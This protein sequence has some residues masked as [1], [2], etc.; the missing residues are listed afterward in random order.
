MRGGAQFR[1]WT[2]THDLLAGVYDAINANTV[3]TG[4]FKK[5]PKIPPWPR[6]TRKPKRPKTV[7]DIRKH[8]G[9]G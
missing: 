4:N 7:A 1:G 9:R 6:P 3:A 8:F 2:R 5:K